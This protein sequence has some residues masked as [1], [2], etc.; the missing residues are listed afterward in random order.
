MP[1]SHG[2]VALEHSSC[3]HCR[4]TR[5]TSAMSPKAAGLG[6]GGAAGDDDAGA[7]NCRDGPCA[8]PGLACRTASAVTAQVLMMMALSSPA[9]SAFDL[10]HRG[11]ISALSRQPN[12]SV[13]TLMGANLA[14]GRNPGFVRRAAPC[15]GGIGSKR[16]GSI[17]SSAGPVSTTWSS[18]TPFDDQRSPP[19]SVTVTACDRCGLRARA[20]DH[21]RAGRRAAGFG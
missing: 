13:S 4:C 18:A 21:R 9:F 11:F 16:A 5:S 10:H 14:S 2:P 20:I 7:G 6:L 15:A 1:N 17:R 12:V 3:R 19:G 8:P